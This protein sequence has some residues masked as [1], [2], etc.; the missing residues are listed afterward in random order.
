MN[1]RMLVFHKTKLKFRPGRPGSRNFHQFKIRDFILFNE[2]VSPKVGWKAEYP[3]NALPFLED[4][5]RN[6][7]IYKK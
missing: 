2:V 7:W 5:I 6:L 3:I 1:A 4:C